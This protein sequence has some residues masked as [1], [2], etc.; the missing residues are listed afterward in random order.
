MPHFEYAYV[1]RT[2][3]V[4]ELTQ[5]FNASRVQWYFMFICM[6]NASIRLPF[7]ILPYDTSYSVTRFISF[8]ATSS[9]R[10][11]RLLILLYV[12]D[13]S[14]PSIISLSVRTMSVPSFGNMCDVIF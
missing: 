11:L 1:C 5:D 14:H 8:T 9:T 7:F 4:T 2:V 13:S 6:L 12:S 3:P 10:F